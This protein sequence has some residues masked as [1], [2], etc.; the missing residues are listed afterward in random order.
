[1]AKKHFA[2]IKG[3]QGK[4]KS[5]DGKRGKDFVLKVPLGTIIKEVGELVYD[6]EDWEAMPTRTITTLADLSTHN[7]TYVAARGGLGGLGN[8]RFV[9]QYAKSS[10]EN[11][12]HDKAGEPRASAIALRASANAMGAG[13]NAMRASA[14]SV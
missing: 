5:L 9:S 6:E 3:T 2:A 10:H 12:V 14:N 8:N 11:S 7:S 1:M 4:G 13:A